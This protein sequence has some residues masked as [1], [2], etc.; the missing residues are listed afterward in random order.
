MKKILFLFSIVLIS[1]GKP[2]QILECESLLN[3][4]VLINKDTFVIV[5]FTY[6]LYILDDVED[7]YILNNGTRIRICD[8][9][10]FLIK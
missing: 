9:N 6:S 10:N 3:K 4:K 5:N 8:I 2:K 1:C 7:E